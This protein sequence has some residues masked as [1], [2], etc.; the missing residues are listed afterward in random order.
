MCNLC[1]IRFFRISNYDVERQ[2]DGFE[3]FKSKL[4]GKFFIFCK[5]ADIG[6]CGWMWGYNSV[7]EVLECNVVC[8]GI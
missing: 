1:S 5:R 3:K 4:N 8:F 7:Q 6:V 2:L